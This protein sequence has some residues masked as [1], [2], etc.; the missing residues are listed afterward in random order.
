MAKRERILFAIFAAALS[1]PVGAQPCA[2]HWE[3]FVFTR[4]DILPL[5]D[6]VACDSGTDRIAVSDSPTARA[7][8]ASR[9]Q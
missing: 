4:T 3:S 6:M 8:C 7:S 1:A 2:G 9:G 5:R